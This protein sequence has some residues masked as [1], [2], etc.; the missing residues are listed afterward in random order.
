MFFHIARYPERFR[1]VFVISFER[2]HIIYAFVMNYSFKLIKLD[3]ITISSKAE[4]NIA[5][6][7]GQFLS[8]TFIGIEIPNTGNPRFDQIGAGINLFLR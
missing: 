8:V 6:F 2:I 4:N 3:F 5:F 1:I 7:P